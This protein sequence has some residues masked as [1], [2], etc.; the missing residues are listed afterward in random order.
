MQYAK[1]SAPKLSVKETSEF[2]GVS[3]SW[4]NKARLAGNGPVF[5]K[6]SSRVVYDLADI[7]SWLASRKF[8]STSAYTSN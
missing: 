1:T 6:I 5:A 2:M 7:E 8:S 4:L 3:E